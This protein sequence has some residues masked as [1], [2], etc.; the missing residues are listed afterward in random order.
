MKT[1]ISDLNPEEPSRSVYASM[2]QLVLRHTD[3]TE[4]LHR[5]KVISICYNK[6]WSRSLKINYYRTSR[7]VSS[8]Y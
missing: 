8:E 3:Y 5:F 4:H 6:Q 7:D 1:L 2:C